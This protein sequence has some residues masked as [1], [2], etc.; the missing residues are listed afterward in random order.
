MPRPHDY[1]EAGDPVTADF[2]Y[3]RWLGDRK[4]IEEQTTRWDRVI[5]NR[6]REMK[7]WID[8]ILRLL[9]RRGR[10]YGYFNNHWQGHAPGSIKLFKELWENSKTG[11]LKR[12]PAG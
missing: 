4:G 2:S 11:L 5:V 6:K 3:I 8:V 10:V 1:F 7:E 12:E 9:E